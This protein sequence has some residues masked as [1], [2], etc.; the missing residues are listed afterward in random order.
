MAHRYTSTHE[1]LTCSSSAGR[2]GAELA[3]RQRSVGCRLALSDTHSWKL[4]AALPP[5]ASVGW[6][7]WSMRKLSSWAHTEPPHTRQTVV[8]ENICRCEYLVV[9]RR[10]AH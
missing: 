7:N 8:D 6:L 2:S 10:Q 1:L 3:S 4:G 5:R 9:R